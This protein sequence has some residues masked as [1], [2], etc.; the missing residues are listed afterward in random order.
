MKGV[1][2]CIGSVMRTKIAEQT[3]YRSHFFLSI[4]LMIAGD[5]LVPMLTLLVYSSGYL[6]QVGHSMR[7]YLFKGYLD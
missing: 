4:F 6:F 3:A 1:L 5:L 7:L 2:L